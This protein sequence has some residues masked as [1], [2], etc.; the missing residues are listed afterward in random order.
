MSIRRMSVIVVAFVV[1]AVLPFNT[2]AQQ[3]ASESGQRPKFVKRAVGETLLV[4]GT[5]DLYERVLLAPPDLGDVSEGY[6]W[7][8]SVDTAIKLGRLSEEERWRVIRRNLGLSQEAN[9]D[10]ILWTEVIN[11]FF[12]QIKGLPLEN[13]AQSPAFG[14][15]VAF[16]GTED[17]ATAEADVALTFNSDLT[18]DKNTQ[19]DFESRLDENV[20]AALTGV[21]VFV[22]VINEDESAALPEEAANVLANLKL[23][24]SDRNGK[25]L[26]PV[27][28][29]Q[30]YF[31]FSPLTVDPELG[32]DFKLQAG[33]AAEFNSGEKEV[34]TGISEP[35]GLYVPVRR[36]VRTRLNLAAVLRDKEFKSRGLGEALASVSAVVSMITKYVGPNLLLPAIIQEFPENPGLHLGVI[37]VKDAGLQ[38][39]YSV[40]F[41]LKNPQLDRR[42]R[43]VS[44]GKI[45][46]QS[47]SRA[48]SEGTAEP[49]YIKI[50]WSGQADPAQLDLQA[51][52]VVSFPLG[53]T[54]GIAP[55][56]DPALYAVGAS[57]KL[58]NLIEIFAGAGIRE[59]Y[60]TAFVYGLTL[61]ISNIIS[62]IT[63]K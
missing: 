6:T 43:F 50:V 15:R 24:L 7:E 1:L 41:F 36:G 18:F 37:Q 54:I 53:I 19:K 10:L 59:E 21:E 2:P 32:S 57:Y 27:H 31:C 40:R 56:L 33:M 39:F 42:P 35:E 25:E 49:H 51:R 45:R 14:L 20:V 38:P 63:G 9:K 26:V 47:L 52:P 22:N 3:S 30:G 48:N 60:P 11:A 17:A 12:D 8:I 29:G 13:G 44:R 23:R 62:E 4:D 34:H 58:F 55:H 16:P 61:D 28:H 5:S 46:L